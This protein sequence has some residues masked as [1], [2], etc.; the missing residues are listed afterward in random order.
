MVM[1]LALVA[2]FLL[3]LSSVLQH[4]AAQAAAPER[5][6]RPGLLVDLLRKPLWLA[7]QG[8]AMTGFAAQAVALSFG[9]LSVVQPLVVTRLVFGLFIAARVSHQAVARREWLGA[10]AIMAG[11]GAFL[12]AASPG[13]GASAMSDRGWLGVLLVTGVPAAAL[14]VLAPRAPGVGR[15]MS[16]AAAGALLFVATTTLTKVVG[17]EL[18]GDAAHVLTSWKLYA[19]APTGIGAMLLVQSAWMAGPIRASLPVLTCVEC[20]GAIAV[21][22]LFLDEAVSIQGLDVAIEVIGLAAVIWGVRTVTRSR[23]LAAT[24]EAPPAGPPRVA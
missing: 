15:A 6:L 13:E 12:V 8:L 9:A 3:G 1:V 7:G 20:L 16:L 17:H 21:G 14:V 23:V 24:L 4:K 18:R 10:L 2:A 5:S 22:V 19:L 11:L